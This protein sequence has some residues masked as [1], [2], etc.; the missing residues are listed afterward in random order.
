MAQSAEC[1]VLEWGWVFLALLVVGGLIL[2]GLL[3]LLISFLRLRTPPANNSEIGY[4]KATA[5][6]PIVT[7]FA[8]LLALVAVGWVVYLGYDKFRTAY[9][10]S[11]DTAS[12]P[13]MDLESLR[14][15]FQEDS[16]AT[17]IVRDP[18]KKFLVTGRFEGACVQDL[19]EAICRRY[20]GQ[21]SCKTSLLDRTL[22]VDR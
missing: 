18:A 5:K 10:V 19:F 8:Y 20:V 22:I 2:C 1:L 17:I 9:S 4:D 21:L 16:R 6:G 15:K 7:Y 13:G 11:F 12:T 14:D 3:A